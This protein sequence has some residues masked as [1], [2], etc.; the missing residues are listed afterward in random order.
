M[1]LG[2][3]ARIRITGRTGEELATLGEW[4]GSEDELRGR[5]RTVRG[6]IHETELGPVAQSIA[7]KESQASALVGI[8]R[9]GLQGL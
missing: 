3:D 7:D 6:P 5:V 2:M 9:I 4:L 8:A 1:G